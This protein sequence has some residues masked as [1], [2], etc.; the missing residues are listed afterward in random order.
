[1]KSGH[2][3]NLASPQLP[4]EAVFKQPDPTPTIVS[5]IGDDGT[6]PKGDLPSHLGQVGEPRAAGKATV[7]ATAT[8]SRRYLRPCIS[9]PSC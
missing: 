3:P 4:T 5:S 9:E 8:Y 7:Q 1:M 2:S 6:C